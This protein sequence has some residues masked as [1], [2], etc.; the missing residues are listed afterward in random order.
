MTKPRRPRRRRRMRPRATRSSREHGPAGWAKAASRKPDGRMLAWLFAC[1]GGSAIEHGG[2]GVL[3]LM[4]RPLARFLTES[5]WRGAW[6][7]SS[8]FRRTERPKRNA[9]VGIL[10]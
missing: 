7:T 6:R 3:A 9:E 2:C 1:C 5:F 8:D 10:G 4:R